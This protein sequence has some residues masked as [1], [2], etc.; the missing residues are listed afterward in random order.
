MSGN[1]HA[2]RVTRAGTEDGCA[3]LSHQVA[4][5]DSGFPA[6]H[7]PRVDLAR[8]DDSDRRGR[9]RPVLLSSNRSSKR[10]GAES[11]GTKPR[12]G[13]SRTWTVIQTA[14]AELGTAETGKRRGKRLLASLSKSKWRKLVRRLFK[15][16]CGHGWYGQYVQNSEWLRTREADSEC[17]H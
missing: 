3:T 10:Q 14:C 11:V 6:S 7:S 12:R 17:G 13:S 2:V 9:R 5:H 1:K 15:V 16:R 8:S 4:S